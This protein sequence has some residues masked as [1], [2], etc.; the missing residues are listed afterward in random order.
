MSSESA[1]KRAEDRF[2]EQ[3]ER[4]LAAC[5]DWLRDNASKLADAFA[6][7]CVDWSIEFH[8]HTADEWDF[9]QIDIRV[10]KVPSDIIEAYY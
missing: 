4:G 10:N 2:Y 3:T 9:P 5:G 6:G 1:H 8:H 7:G